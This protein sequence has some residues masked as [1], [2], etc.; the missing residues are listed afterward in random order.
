MRMIILVELKVGFRL[1]VKYTPWKEKHL[2][3]C[4][5]S[6]K[7]RSPMFFFSLSK[8]ATQRQEVSHETTKLAVIF[9]TKV[10]VVRIL[11]RIYVTI[12]QI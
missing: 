10:L 5:E 9:A 6:E 2:G 4:L 11:F 7:L 3:K 12:V 1:P 8:P